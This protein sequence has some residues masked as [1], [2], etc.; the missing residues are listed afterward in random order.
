MHRRTSH[1]AIMKDFRYLLRTLRRS[2]GHASA[3]ILTLALGIG[4]TT[5]IVSVVDYVL[6]RHL[7]FDDAGRLVM[8]VETDG[9]GGFRVPSNPTAV[10]W[11]SDPASAQAFEGITYIRGDGVQVCVADQCQPYGS[12]YV[13]PDFFPLLRPRVQMGRLLA[14]DDAQSVVISNRLWR[15]Q[16]GSDPN[17]I[18]RRI[19]IDSVPKVIVGLL[20]SGAVY[21]PFADV[22]QPLASYKSPE[23]MQRRGFHADSRTLGR[24]KPGVDSARAARAM[25]VVSARLG[26][27]YP[28]DQRGWAASTITLH[29]EL[30]GNVRQMLLT[31]AA[32]GALI[33]VLVCANVAGL[34]ITRGIGRRRELAIRVAIGAAPGQIARQLLTESAGYALLG[35]TLGA[36]LAAAGVSAARKLLAAQLPAVAELTIDVRMLAVAVSAT[37]VCALA[38]GLFPAIA[39][40]RRASG[41]T[42]A[43]VGSAQSMTPTSSR[44]RQALVALQ[45]AMALVLLVGAG[46][47]THSL[48]RAAD[49]NVGFEPKGLYSMRIVPRNLPDASQRAALYQRLTE[50]MRTVPGVSEAAFINHAPFYGASITSTMLVDGSLKADSSNQLFYRTASSTYPSVM[51]TTMRE[52]RWFTEAEERVGTAAFVVNE[53][54]ARQYWGK[55]SPVGSRVRLARA[56]QS[57]KDFGTFMSGMVIGVVRDVH[58]VGQDIAPAAEVYV[59]YTVEPWGW[60]M[61]MVRADQSALPAMREAVRSVD[62]RLVTEANKTPFNSVDNAV[63]SQLEPRRF[64]IRLIGAFALTGIALA[65]L[66]LYGVMA[67]NVTQRTREFA[68]RKAMG[69]TDGRVI[70]LVLGNSAAIVVA[71][72]VIGGIG[73]WG[74]ARWISGL[75][76]H[77]SAL[78]PLVYVAAVAGLTLIA[79]ASSIVPALRASKLD[80]AIALRQ[81]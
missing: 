76:F 59:P 51:R 46:L 65:C 79:T 28:E 19:L 80:P 40:L 37:A 38:C 41:S 72:T 7:P 67:Y 39:A 69:A 77:T 16:L 4:A 26:T 62:A 48:V 34:L 74:S 63:T 17:V 42:L 2:P 49:V 6:L 55:V 53:T 73:A 24:L 78:D 3:I 56:N 61:L 66:G 18:G 23:I 81:E 29:Q 30:L 75:L 60:G 68:V 70:R 58:Q 45:F 57:A 43:S 32:A 14:G 52:G 10:D 20:T 36:L 12:A 22:W 1:I 15:S 27:Q 64:A 35:G 44:T 8:M 54:A 31:F 50:A 13:K 11:S 47:L 9:K 33:L 5:A 71:G 25:S 21:P